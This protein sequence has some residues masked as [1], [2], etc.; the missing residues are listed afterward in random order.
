MFDFNDSLSIDEN[1]ANITDSIQDIQTALVTFATRD[2]SINGLEVKEGSFIGLDDETIVTTSNNKLKVT[3][4]LLKQ[5][6]NEE[7]E[8]VTVFYGNDVSTEEV[9][10]LEKIFS[11]EYEDIELEIHEGNQPIYSFIIMVE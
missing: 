10:Q 2:T 5:V 7:D 11:I 9:A 6:V 8:I 1:E 4:Q 3:E